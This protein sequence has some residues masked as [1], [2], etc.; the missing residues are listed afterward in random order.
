MINWA[1]YKQGIKSNLKLCLVFVTILTLYTTMVI[2]MYDPQL[3][4]TLEE[5]FRIMPDVMSMMGMNGDVTSLNSFIV[6]YLYGFIFIIFPMVFS[7]ILVNKLIISHIDR[8]SMS[9]LLASPNSRR[10]IILT[11]LK[12]IGTYIFVLILYSTVL[13]IVTCQLMFPNELNIVAFLILNLGILIFHYALNGISFLASCIFN[14]SKNALLIGIGLPLIF[15]IIQML[16][17][18]G[19]KLEKFKYITLFTLFDAMGLINRITSAYYG[20]IVLLIISVAL[21]ALGII[22]FKKRDLSV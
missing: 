13:S 17:N 20:I 12:V 4:K 21:Y 10:K 6:T 3:A 18:M 22:I 15:F 9:Y 7:I 16:V 11:Q 8:G 1:L 19:G 5:F 14:D 2:S